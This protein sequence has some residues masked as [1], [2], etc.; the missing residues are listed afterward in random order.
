MQKTK[1]AFPN[2]GLESFYR[3]SCN[4]ENKILGF[5][6]EPV[7]AKLTRS[8]YSEG[9]DKDKAENQYDRLSTKERSTCEKKCEQCKRIPT[10]LECLCCRKIPEVEA[11]HLKRIAIL[12]WNQVAL[13][14]FAKLVESSCKGNNFLEEFFSEIF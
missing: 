2:R 9:S 10:S 13:E 7:C 1:L 8:S 12:F 3:V 5:K 11:F 14:L 4:I 6:F